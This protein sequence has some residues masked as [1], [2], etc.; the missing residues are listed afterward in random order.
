MNSV[1]LGLLATLALV[2]ASFGTTV[3]GSSLQT[4]L[5]NISE[6]GVS[7]TNVNTD[8]V[9][10][11]KYWNLTASGGSVATMIIEIAGYAGQNEFGIYEATNPSNKVTLFHGGDQA[12][13]FVTVS[14][15]A[16]GNVYLSTAGSSPVTTFSGPTFGYFLKS[17]TTTFYSNDALNSDAADHMVAYQG[18]GQTVT[19]PGNYPG[20]WTNNEYILAWEDLAAPGADFDFDDMVV[21]VESV[22]PVPEPT[23]LGLM[24]LGLMSLAFAARRRNK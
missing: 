10:G 24:G 20:E 8:Q 11:D 12:G 7:T 22:K 15:K 23:T 18:K 3:T 1:K 21:M 14:I 5:N 4:V 17:P 16:N 6:G 9:A 13:D 19:T 2:G